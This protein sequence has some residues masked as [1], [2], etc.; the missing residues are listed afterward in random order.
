MYARLIFFYYLK[1]L[2]CE[3]IKRYEKNYSL[4]KRTSFLEERFRQNIKSYVE[5]D[6]A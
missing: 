4:F 3:L 6:I 1:L 5:L 2:I